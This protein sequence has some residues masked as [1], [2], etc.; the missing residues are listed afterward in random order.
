MQVGDRV[1]CVN[2]K[3]IGT[4]AYDIIKVGKIYTVAR[5]VTGTGLYA[6][7]EFVHVFCDGNEQLKHTPFY[8]NRFQVVE[9]KPPIKLENTSTRQAQVHPG[10]RTPK[11]H[12]ESQILHTAIN[13]IHIQ[14][15]QHPVKWHDPLEK[16]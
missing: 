16:D 12:F 15:N 4:H 8:S 6:G 1:V 7:Q 9:E 2:N 3:T 10:L 5:I 11:Q 13:M 14:R